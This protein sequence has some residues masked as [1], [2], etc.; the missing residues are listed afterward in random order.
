[1]KPKAI[2]TLETIQKVV[3]VSSDSGEGCHYCDSQLGLDVRI[4]EKI[5]HYI[6][7]GYK[8]LH[9]GTETKQEDKGQ[10]WYRTVAVLGI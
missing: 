2:N 8:L 10:L 5:N 3:W 6:G 9:I 7:H 4:D 1:M